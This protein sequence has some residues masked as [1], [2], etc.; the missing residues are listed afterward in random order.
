MERLRELAAIEGVSADEG[1]VADYVAHAL[2]E[3]PGTTLRRVG[4]NLIVVRGR[5]RVAVV[6]HLDTV[7]FTL[8][9]DHALIS[10]GSPHVEGG[11]ALRSTIGG[12]TWRGTVEVIE[13]ETDDMPNGGGSSLPASGRAGG[14]V[15]LAGADDAP[16]GSRWVFDTPLGQDGE[17]LI[18]AYLDNR[19]GVWCA[20]AVLERCANVAVAFTVGEEQSGRGA[21]IC[22]RI[23]H[24][25]L[26]IRQALISDITWH[27]EHVHRGRGPAVSL[28]D[29]LMPRQA[30][31]DRV[32]A[33]ADASGIP[34]QRE[35][36]SGGGSDGAG[37]ERSG[38]PIDW[39]FI[40]ACQ[41]NT[42]TPRE[43]VD[44][45]D[46]QAMIELYV[47]LVDRL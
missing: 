41:E 17:Q 11:E 26:G 9:Y 5:P 36:E 34:Y 28:R 20:M 27:T 3:V 46:L 37:I 32:L 43:I 39:C 47:F 25:D 14:G 19:A 16:P 45:A 23:L 24:D 21:G 6:A 29:R 8:G 4:D 13:E 2:A 10:I 1:R 30:Y 18:G 33:L 44:W 15:R 22:A 7:G 38:L 12:T 42:H 31:L 35:I 40:G